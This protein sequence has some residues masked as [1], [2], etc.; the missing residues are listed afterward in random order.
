M[1]KQVAVDVELG[2]ISEAPDVVE[3]R[4]LPVDKSEGYEVRGIFDFIQG[5]DGNRRV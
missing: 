3:V 5:P 2:Q 4:H 1:L